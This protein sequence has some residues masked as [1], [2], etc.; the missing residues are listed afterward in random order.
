MKV[1]ITGTAGFIGSHVAHRIIN[2]G[3]DVVGIDSLNDYYS[4]QLKFDRLRVLGG[5]PTSKIQYGEFTRSE[6]FSN[7]R[8]M[9]L[10]T[11]DKERIEALFEAEKFDFVCHLASQSGVRYS[12][13]NPY[14]Y[15]ENNINGFITIL[16]GC[17]YHSV[18]NLVYASSSSVYGDSERI[19]FRENDNVDYPISLYAATKKSNELMAHAYSHLYSIPTVGLRFFTVYGPWGRPDM[20]P[21]IFVQSIINKATIK[22]YNNGDLFRDFTYI[23]DVVEGVVRTLFSP[24]ER[25][26]NVNIMQS[27]F[28]E[29][30]NIGNH[31]PVS[32]SDFIKVIEEVCGEKAIIKKLPMQPGDVHFTHADT[33]KLQE[34]IGFSPNTSLKVGISRFVKWYLEYYQA[35]KRV[36]A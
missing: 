20:A 8:F 35:H 30:Y 34:A 27:R 21:F 31:W 17:R 10:N 4:V 28:Y 19:P 24:S 2:L 29:I 15:I 18:K 23:D 13:E 3:Y 1:L 9:H 32:I 16:E 11:S 26:D 36:N 25:Q 6:K 14:A 33:S 5:V 22:V 12:V 7:Y